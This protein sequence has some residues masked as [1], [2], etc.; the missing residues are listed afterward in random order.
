M[1]RTLVALLL[2]AIVVLVGLR[3]GNWQLN[4]AAERLNIAATIAA[5]RASTPLQL[6]ARTPTPQ[7]SPWR[8]ASANG[9]WLHQYTVLV[10]NR[11]YG[12]RPGYWVA[13]PLLLEQD[14]GPQA[15]KQPPVALLVLRGWM[16]RPVHP[17]QAQQPIPAPTGT[18]TVQGELLDRVPRLLQLWSWS[19]NPSGQLPATWPKDTGTPVVVQN[20]DL[21]ELSQVSGL[22]LLPTVLAANP[23]NASGLLQEWPEPSLDADKNRGYA[24]QWFGFAAIAGIAWIVVL[25]RALRRK[26]QRQSDTI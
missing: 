22:H 15:S 12:G 4:R 7:L 20:L 14:S 26:R 2:L 10:D 16:P 19:K 11:S 8:S 9:T 17:G 6:S 21:H 23:D 5:G 24:L 1:L 25:W 13:T 18:Q 3:L